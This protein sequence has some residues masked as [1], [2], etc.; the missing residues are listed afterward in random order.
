MSAVGKG[1]MSMEVP[2][3]PQASKLKL[4]DVLHVPQ[5]GYTLVS[6][7]QL[8]K[9]GYMVTFSG[10]KCVLTAPDRKRVGAIPMTKQGLY[11][12]MNNVSDELAGVAKEVL[13][14]DL[15]HRH[16]GH[17]S[18]SSACSLVQNGMVT[19]VKLD[20]SLLNKQVFCE[21]CIYAKA[22]RKPIPKV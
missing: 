8:D 19:G 16:M 13:T 17:I 22:T 3:G 4:T 9:A 14:L 21:S 7:G 18:P 6:V 5:V 11:K 12:V 2:N 10:H 20:A 15:F 1:E